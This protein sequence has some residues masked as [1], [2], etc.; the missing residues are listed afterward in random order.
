MGCSGIVVR[1]YSLRW[2][3]RELKPRR[4]GKKERGETAAV[5]LFFSRM[6]CC[7]N[8]LEL[9]AFPYVFVYV[10]LGGREGMMTLPI[11]PLPGKG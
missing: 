10:P 7:S 2:G 11:F 8:P 6:I 9:W 5:L 3:V 1:A 4:K